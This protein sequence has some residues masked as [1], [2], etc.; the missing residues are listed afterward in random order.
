MI[1]GV[2]NKFNRG[3]VGQESLAR[4][5]VKRIN[6]SASSAE[7]LL[8]RSPNPRL[9][10]FLKNSGLLPSLPLTAKHLASE[11][12]VFTLGLLVPS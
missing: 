12:E 3:E 2:V 4:D 8:V 6:N 7:K 1:R 5:D 11:K 10:P 9:T